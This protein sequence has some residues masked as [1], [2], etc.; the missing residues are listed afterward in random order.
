MLHAQMLHAMNVPE[1]DDLVA[2]GS[3]LL[4]LLRHP[5]V[6]QLPVIAAERELCA[7]VGVGQGA[8]LQ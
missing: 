6:V 5:G 1:D 4:H 2:V 8:V 3:K 7:A